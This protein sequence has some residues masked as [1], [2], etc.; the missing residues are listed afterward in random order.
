[1]YLFVA[2]DKADFLVSATVLA[3]TKEGMMLKLRN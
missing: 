1:M 3:Q 2:W